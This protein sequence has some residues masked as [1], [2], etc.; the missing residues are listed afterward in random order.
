RIADSPIQKVEIGIVSARRP[1]RPAT[2]LPRIAFPGFTAGFAGRRNGVEAPKLLA[3]GWTIAGEESANTIFT[4]GGAHDD[5]VLHNKRS[6]GNRIAGLRRTDRNVPNQ[7][8]SLRIDREQSSVDCP[9]EQRIAE[10][11]E[12]AI[13]AATANA[14][15]LSGIVIVGP[16]SASGN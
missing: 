10:N 14:C 5:L 6:D 11:R 15:S 9:H 16:E 2:G 4:A 13:N 3:I 12:S 7:R 1:D 8:A